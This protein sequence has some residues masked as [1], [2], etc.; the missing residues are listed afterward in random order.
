V[1]VTNTQTRE[2]LEMAGADLVV[3]SLEEVTFETLEALA[4]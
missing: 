2:T 4:G 1:A 3:S